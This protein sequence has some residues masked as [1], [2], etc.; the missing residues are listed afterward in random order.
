MKV[1]YIGL[2]DT[3]MEP[4]NL[5]LCAIQKRTRHTFVQCHV[6][7]NVNL[8]FYHSTYCIPPKSKMPGSG[9]FPDRHFTLTKYLKKLRARDYRGR[10]AFTCPTSTPHTICA[11]TTQ[12]NRYNYTLTYCNPPSSSFVHSRPGGIPP[13]R[14]AAPSLAAR[15]ELHVFISVRSTE[16]ILT[17]SS[18]KALYRLY[19]H[20]LTV[21]EQLTKAANMV[22]SEQMAKVKAERLPFTWGL[23]GAHATLRVSNRCKKSP[24]GLGAQ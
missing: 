4:A 24:R 20:Y 7:K 10:P 8:F 2:S 18:L 14:G 19:R 12:I 5:S 13:V 23:W 22:T 11:L 17:S 21:L 3:R 16:T 6:L 1:C 9:F 15:C